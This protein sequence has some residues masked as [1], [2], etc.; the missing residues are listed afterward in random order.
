[1]R[2]KFVDVLIL[3]GLENRVAEVS[4]VINVLFWRLLKEVSNLLIEEKE[5][6]IILD[7]W[8]NFGWK[9]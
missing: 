9:L 8:E 6:D 4:Q 1:M 5:Q 3:T 2:D 7:F